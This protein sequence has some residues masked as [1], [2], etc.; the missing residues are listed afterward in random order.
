MSDNLL[1]LFDSLER[2]T[3][4]D[5]KKY[6]KKAPFGWPGGKSRSIRFILPHLPQ[7]HTYVEPFGGS[8]VVLLNRQVSRLEVFNDRYAGII[9][10]YQ[11]LRSKE[12]CTRL[13]EWLDLT[14]NSREEWLRCAETWEDQTDLI[15]RAGRWY[16]MHEYSF[17]SLGRNW[18]R[19]RSGRYTGI[20]GKIAKKIKCFSEVH[21]RFRNVQIENLDGIE[22]M[23]QYDSKHTVF[24]VDPPY[25]D[26]DQG[27]YK[28]QVCPR[29]HRDLMEFIFNCKGFVALSGYDNPFYTDYDWDAKYDWDVFVSIQGTSKNTGLKNVV[30][31][32][33]R[34]KTQE[35]L[36]IKEAK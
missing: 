35:C 30:D 23:E 14:V 16:Y 10:F 11:C 20:N 15:E 6:P 24:Y 29:Y 28:H 4:D 7:T 25:I 26:C 27:V 33:E 8:G 32:M 1:D 13:M 21:E 22:C 12:L 18:G 17:G 36:W 34:G 3:T 19:A 2:A 31:Q 9:A 5:I